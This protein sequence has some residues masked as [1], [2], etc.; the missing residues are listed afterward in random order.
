MVDNLEKNSF[1]NKLKYA[2]FNLMYITFIN[3]STSI[4]VLYFFNFIEILQILALSINDG[5]KIVWKGSKF[6]TKVCD[7]LKYWRILRFTDNN[8]NFY[9]FVLILICLI[10]IFD[11]ILYLYLLI[12]SYNQNPLK[13]IFVQ[14]FYH[15]S[16]FISTIFLIPNTEVLFSMIV[17]DNELYFKSKFNCWGFKHIIFVTLTSLCYF[18]MLTITIL[19]Q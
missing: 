13:N 16:F 4:W 12:L 8:E 1:L 6:Y 7:F 10:I 5:F 19:F 18:F 3:Y 15:L 9:L 2:N 11:F 14:I 17:C